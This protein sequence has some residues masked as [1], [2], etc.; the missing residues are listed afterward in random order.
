MRRLGQFRALCRL[1]K[2]QVWWASVKAVGARRG[3]KGSIAGKHEDTCLIRS[4]LRSRN[5]GFHACYC[6]NTSDMLQ[7]KPTHE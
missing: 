3:T 6:I 2:A 5:T 1:L 7:S 4:R